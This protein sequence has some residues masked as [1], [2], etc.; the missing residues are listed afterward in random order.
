[1]KKYIENLHFITQDHPL[2]SHIEQ[3]Q[4]ACQAGA[5]WIQ[6]RC[7]TKND[8]ELLSDIQE[9]AACCDDWGAT[10][11]VTEHTHLSKLA[12]IQG[13]HLEDP[14]ADIAGVK[15]IL[16]EEFTVGGTAHTPEE[17]I[18]LAGA[19]ADYVGYGPFRPSATLALP[20]PA[21][22]IPGYLQLMPAIQESDMPV[23]AVGGITASD[24][25][26]LMET[27]IFGI[28]VSAAISQAADMEEAYRE[29]YAGLR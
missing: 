3:V 5:K 19:G 11:I 6:Y 10:L 16:G 9:I 13:F 22:G 7:F 1:M 15:A 14:E 26:A 28:A 23:I 29:F 21:Q 18:R 8:G 24:I 27:G 2:R 20:L 4:I 17:L 25:P 12:D